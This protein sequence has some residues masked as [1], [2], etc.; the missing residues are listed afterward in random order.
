MFNRYLMHYQPEP[1]Y[2]IYVRAWIGDKTIIAASFDHNPRPI[3]H[4]SHNLQNNYTISSRRAGQLAYRLRALG[5]T[6]RPSLLDLGWT[7]YPPK[8]EQTK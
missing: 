4:N 6:F 2:A 1:I 3:P 8:G 5:W 7:A